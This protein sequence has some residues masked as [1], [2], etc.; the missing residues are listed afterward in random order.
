MD[1][2]FKKLKRGLKIMRPGEKPI[3]LTLPLWQLFK[4]RTRMHEEAGVLHVL[5]GVISQ[6]E[7]LERRDLIQRRY[8]YVYRGMHRATYN[9]LTDFG[10]A[11]FEQMPACPPEREWPEAPKAALSSPTNVKLSEHQQN[12]I[13]TWT[14]GLSTALPVGSSE[15]ESSRWQ[16][17]ER[18]GKATTAALL[19]QGLIEP[20]IKGLKIVDGKVELE[21]RV[22]EIHL[23][24]RLT[25]L[26]AMH[27]DN[28]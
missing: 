13:N 22:G 16:L 6:D 18:R 21:D 4:G 10:R 14:T 3:T 12:V 8:N 11:V 23:V 20:G 15:L 5:G 1:L 28:L 27:S 19:R 26:G 9:V 17:P 25:V 24:Y 7:A 2:T